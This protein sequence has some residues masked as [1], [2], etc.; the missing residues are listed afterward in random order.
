MSFPNLD[1]KSGGQ[2]KSL[3]SIL[4]K[5]KNAPNALDTFNSSTRTYERRGSYE[6]RIPEQH[7][8]QFLDPN[9]TT[10]FEVKNRQIE[11]NSNAEPITKYDKNSLA[12]AVHLLKEKI[13]EKAIMP[14]DKL[15][16]E[17]VMLFQKF[18]E[19]FADN[20]ENAPVSRKW[21]ALMDYILLKV[22]DLDR[23]YM[24]DNYFGYKKFLLYHII[25]ISLSY[26]IIGG[27]TTT[28]TTGDGLNIPSFNGKNSTGSNQTIFG[29]I[30]KFIKHIPI[31]MEK[32]S[33]NHREI[34][35]LDQQH[36]YFLEQDSAIDSTIH[37]LR[38]NTKS[39]EKEL[40]KK[41]SKDNK[42]ALNRSLEEN[43]Q[44]LEKT[45]QRKAALATKIKDV[46]DKKNNLEN[47]NKSEFRIL[48]K[49]IQFNYFMHDDWC[50]PLDYGLNSIM[51]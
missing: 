27:E 9:I 22:K 43:K 47:D 15:S 25:N 14:V 10:S 17:D 35:N 23:K 28:T 21:L 33:N 7:K 2:S 12:Y 6:P 4:G 41:L 19:K 49:Y 46:I 16:R 48:D 39:Q 42:D 8:K 51:Q 26:I 44:T 36:T 1:I 45:L 32:I 50:P 30:N 18:Q 13:M 38:A 11:L 29:K 20:C 5:K 3:A 31:F 24:S 34:R 37:T 40:D